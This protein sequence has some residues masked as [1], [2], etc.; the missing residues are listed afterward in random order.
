MCP[1]DVLLQIKQQDLAVP[2]AARR[3]WTPY[4]GATG[5]LEDGHDERLGEP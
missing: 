4:G 3:G 1:V 2:P 5:V